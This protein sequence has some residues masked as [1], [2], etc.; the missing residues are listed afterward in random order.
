ML[1]S[2][3]DACVLTASG[4]HS[5]KQT[6]RFYSY[7]HTRTHALQGS[8][9]MPRKVGSVLLVVGGRH[10]QVDRHLLVS[11]S[12]YFRVLFRRVTKRDRYGAIVVPGDADRFGLIVDYLTGEHH[13]SIDE[14][15]S[16]IPDGASLYLISSLVYLSQLKHE[17]QLRERQRIDEVKR[18][19]QKMSKLKR[20][21]AHLDTH[22]DHLRYGSQQHRLLE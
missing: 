19:M 8:R 22:V 9:A 18:A 6:F 20:E 16:I 1:K 4:T 7:R 12:I 3:L 10:F 17:Y 14:L 2:M 21:I 5:P 13:L 11:Q 15:E